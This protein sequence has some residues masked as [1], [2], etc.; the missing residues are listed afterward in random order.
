MIYINISRY[1]INRYITNKIWS[2]SEIEQSYFTSTLQ[3]M[4]QIQLMLIYVCTSKQSRY[5]N[6]KYDMKNI[7]GRRKKKKLCTFSDIVQSLYYTKHPC[8][9]LKSSYHTAWQTLMLCLDKTFP[10]IRNSKLYH[11]YYSVSFSFI[12]G[13]NH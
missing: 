5:N 8:L 4:L 6:F 11:L 10:I 12:K 13:T 1:K 7:N 9:D 2:L 3:I